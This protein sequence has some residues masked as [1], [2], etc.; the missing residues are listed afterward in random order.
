M[1]EAVMPAVASNS[2]VRQWVLVGAGRAHLHVLAHMARAPW[3]G[4]QVVLV[5]PEP[6]HWCAGMLA[7]YVAGRYTLEDCAI[8]L[9]PLVQRA[10]IRWI[11]SGVRSLDATA[12]T[13]TLEDSSTLRFDGLSIDTEAVQ[14]RAA[15]EEAMP[16]VRTHGLFAQ[17]MGLFGK[18]WPQ[19]VQ[20]GLQRPLRIAVLGGD[21]TAVQWAMAVRARLPKAAVTLLCGDTALAHGSAGLAQRVQVALRNRHITVLRDHAAS[22][23]AGE[24]VLASGATLAC[25]VPVLATGALAPDWLQ[26]SGLALDAHGY[27]AVDACLRSTSHPQVF[28]TGEVSSHSDR[29]LAGS[30]VYAVREAPLLLNNLVAA[31]NSQPL[32]AY[33]PSAHPL[34]LIDCG[35]R[36][37]IAS[38]GGYSAEG[39]WVCWLKDR[40]DRRFIQRY[41]GASP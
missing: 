25:D 19:V 39:R 27:V 28:A 18:L 1:S 20:Q 5:E 17:P 41:S 11:R 15:L 6:Q 22:L 26:R 16:G 21:A 12:Q 8:A 7:G 23:R 38:W 29:A 35:D 4:V 14:H 33:Q 31:L 32:K 13:L 34:S 30:G 10:G 3:R 40:I 9:E 24:V 37:G 36:R 2:A